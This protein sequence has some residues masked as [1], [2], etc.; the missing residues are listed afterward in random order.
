[1]LER[2]LT[3]TVH[4]FDVTAHSSPPSFLLLRSTFLFSFLLIVLLVDPG[5]S[6]MNK[7]VRFFSLGERREGSTAD[8]TAHVSFLW[9]VER[10]DRISPRS[11]T[12]AVP[13]LIVGRTVEH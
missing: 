7:K 13:D 5:P 12:G 6:S 8:K 4:L 2:T 1:M 10:L 11:N 9:F 3:S